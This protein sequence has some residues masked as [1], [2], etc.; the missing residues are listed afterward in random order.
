[1]ARARRFGPK[2]P[3]TPTRGRFAGRKFSSKHAYR[4]EFA[5]AK[6]F[7]SDYSRRIAYKSLSSLGGT[8][9]LSPKTA[10]KRN[11]ALGVVSLMRR[12]NLN[13]A[14]ARREFNRQNP[15]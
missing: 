13:L 11:D 4:N 8:E 9:A 14:Q 15:G 10:Q 3:Y 12:L 1:M 2:P 5:R 6:G 7:R